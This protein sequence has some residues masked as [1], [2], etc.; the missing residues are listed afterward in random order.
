MDVFSV[1]AV[2]HCWNTYSK[3]FKGWFHTDSHNSFILK[4]KKK[5]E[6]VKDTDGWELPDQHLVRTWTELQ[7]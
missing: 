4:C 1:D 7:S 5:K 6:R 3:Y 2:E